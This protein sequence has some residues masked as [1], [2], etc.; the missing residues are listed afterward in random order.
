MTEGKRGER[1]AKG[2]TGR[3][4]MMMD[5]NQSLGGDHDV[6]YTEIEI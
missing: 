6:I 2:V 3:M 1:K 5:G 4:Y